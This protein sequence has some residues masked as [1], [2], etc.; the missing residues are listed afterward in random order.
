MVSTPQEEALLVFLFSSH[1]ISVPFRV[2]GLCC[3]P[4]DEGEENDLPNKQ[5]E[6]VQ[7]AAEGEMY[8]FAGM[9]LGRHASQSC[10]LSV[11]SP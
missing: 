7:P 5:Q 4:T 8:P 10:C 2:Q 11:Y 3:S 1:N 9:L 6:I